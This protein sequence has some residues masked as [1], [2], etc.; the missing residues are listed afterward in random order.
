MVFSLR[1]F[2]TL[3]VCALGLAHAADERNLAARSGKSSENRVA[4]VIGNA[5]YGASPLKN[6]VNDARAIATKLEKLG[7][8][9]VK[10]ENLTTKQIGATLREFRS[11][12][13]PG[14]E[15]LFFYAGHGLQVKGVN[16][17]PAVDAD[18]SSEEDVPNQ[19]INVSQL[20]EIMDDSKTRLN[21]LF[22]DACRNNPFTRRFRSAGGGLAKIEAPSGTKISFATRPGSV[23]ADGEG[24]NGLYTE[25]LLRVM[26]QRGLPIE[27]ALKKVYSG[28]KQASKG[29]QEPWE[30]GTIEGEFYFQAGS[31]GTSALS[32][33]FPQASVSAPVAIDAVVIEME[34]WN[35]VKDSRNSEELKAYLGQFPNGKFASLAR[36]RIKSIGAEAQTQTQIATVAPSITAALP[37]TQQRPTEQLLGSSKLRAQ[38]NFPTKDRRHAAFLDVVREISGASGDTVNFDPLPAGSVVP[39]FGALDAVAKRILDAAWISGGFFYGKDPSFGLLEGAPFGLDPSSYA[40]WRSGKQ[41]SDIVDRLYRQYGVVGLACGVTAPH[42]DIWTKKPIAK[43]DDLRGLKIRVNG[44]QIAMFTKLGSAVN[45]LPG[46][47]IVPAMDR[48]LLDAAIF[49]DPQTD[50]IYG[51]SDVSKVYMVGQ[52]YGARGLDLI[53]N[54]NLWD[55]LRPEVRNTITTACRSNLNRMVGESTRIASEAIAEMKKTVKIYKLPD[56]VVSGLRN[57]WKEVRSEEMAKS[58][59]FSELAATMT[60]YESSAQRP[61]L[62]AYGLNRN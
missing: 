1:L 62:A 9:V 29:A 11:R 43:L 42:G 13:S 28:V 12:L 32:V 34:F 40:V 21:L 45:A 41:A 33:N 55:G 3:A 60:A 25:H 4:L 58:K 18:I 47:E 23:A 48:G 46:S 52:L 24:S 8:T 17:L 57:A 38:G 49:L 20:L 16:Y 50:L 19:S 56:T 54:A 53:I 59:T 26:E 39:S 27:Q 6:P 30:E 15:A 5:A 10:R 37:A 51:F 31:G 2:L 36:A 22:L 35:G 7:F 44:M 14:A 61:N